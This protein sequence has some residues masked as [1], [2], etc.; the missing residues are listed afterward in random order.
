[1][2]K[3]RNKAVQLNKQTGIRTERLSILSWFEK[4]YRLLTIAIL[5][6]AA[7]LRLSLL[8]ELPR[9]PFSQLYK[10]PDLDMN[11]FD[12]WGDRIAH[13][14][15]LTDTVWHPYHFWHAGISKAYGLQTDEEGKQKWNEWYGGK[16]YHQEPL[17]AQI[18][19]LAKMIDGEG[20]MMVY[21]L[22]MLLSLLSIWMVIWLGRHYFTA[23]AGL[24]GGLLFTF[25]GPGLL[26]DVMLIR[27]SFST[28]LMLAC[29]VTGE[30]LIQGKK[31]AW[32]MGLIG[33]AGYLLMT[34]VLLLWIPLVGRWIYLRR[35]DM[36]HLWKVAVAFGLFLSLLIARNSI[37]GAPLFSSSSVG[38]ITYVLSNFPEY[39]PELGFVYFATA[40][41][42]ME[43][44]QGKI[45]PAAL[46]VIR[47][48]DHFTGWI[49][50]QFKKLGMVFHWYEIPNNI[51]SYLAAEFSQTLKVTVIPYSLIAALGLAGMFLNLRNKKVIN[52]HI[53]ILSQIA[54]MVIFYVLC[55]FRVPMVA[56]LCVFAG[57]TLQ[58]LTDVKNIKTFLAAAIGSILLWVV[59]LRPAP[60]IPVR[61]TRGDLN[62]HF[63]VYYLPR[64]DSLSAK[65]DLTGC[66]R[67]IEEFI[68]TRPS[69]IDDR[70]KLQTLKS[71]LERDVAYYYSLV[72]T[73]LGNLY[74]EMSNDTRSKECLETGK[75]LL[76]ASGQQ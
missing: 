20:R 25:Y 1:M 56:M 55:R 48:H 72:Y 61:F 11:F 51:N 13:G 43:S 8:I 12:Q 53:G 74:K 38:P 39:K 21:I 37:V 64:L 6:M 32:V 17:Y 28:T 68:E 5:F 34:T 49:I 18:T 4:H 73:D 60:D 31:R 65:G 70:G 67:L 30:Q 15:F 23:L 71:N 40:G 2:T 36:K 33:G 9:M 41:K 59:I 42:I 24:A 69:F 57:A 27:T 10:A 45:I 29:L 52:L 19:G 35:Q 26:F 76:A 58:Q 47:M 75:R 50:L 14:D 44:S 66:A 46:E 63:S 54:V 62:A 16:Q 7:V 3:P 22:Q